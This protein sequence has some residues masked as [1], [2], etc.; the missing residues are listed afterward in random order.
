MPRRKSTR[1]RQ[2][3]RTR[4]RPWRW[5]FERVVEAALYL[6]RQPGVTSPHEGVKRQR[7]IVAEATMRLYDLL[8]QYHP[9]HLPTWLD[10]MAAGDN[11]SALS[12]IAAE[13]LSRGE[14]LLPNVRAHAANALRNPPAPRSNNYG[15]LVMRNIAIVRMVNSLQHEHNLPPTRNRGSHGNDEA[16]PSGCSIVTRA[17]GGLSVGLSESAIEKV[18]ETSRRKMRRR[19]ND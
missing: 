7:E 11:D 13:L 5:T 12:D 14:T 17:L 16:A 18:W 1:V 3:S 2:V 8:R 15:S 10:N 9:A 4:A 19:T 6:S